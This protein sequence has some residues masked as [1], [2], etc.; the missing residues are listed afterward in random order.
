MPFLS[1]ELAMGKINYVI[2]IN[3][4]L[5]NPTATQSPLPLNSNSTLFEPVTLY[6]TKKSQSLVQE[7]GNIKHPFSVPQP[8]VVI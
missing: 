3:R 4:S 8:S 5:L 2:T 1:D 7:S 6:V